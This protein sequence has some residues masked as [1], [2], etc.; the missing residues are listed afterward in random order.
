MSPLLSFHKLLHTPRPRPLRLPPFFSSYLHPPRPLLCRS[1]AI[2]RLT[3]SFHPSCCRRRCSSDYLDS[4]T[5]LCYGAFCRMTSSS[6]LVVA[7]HPI[8]STQGLRL[9]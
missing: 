5:A 9:L 1:L 6:F 8:I 3:S 7:A 4:R 2:S